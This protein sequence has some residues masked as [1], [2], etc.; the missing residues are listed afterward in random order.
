MEA[1]AWWPSYAILWSK[2]AMGIKHD[3]AV[4]GIPWDA[5]LPSLLELPLG[6]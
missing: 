3:G 6:N 5:E 1:F 4:M 2:Q